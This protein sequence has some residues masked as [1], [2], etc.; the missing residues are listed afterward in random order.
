M[1]CYTCSSST[2]LSLP[3]LGSLPKLHHLYHS[4][5]FF[6]AIKDTDSSASD[7]RYVKN[8]KLKISYL[9][10]FLLDNISKSVCILTSFEVSESLTGNEEKIDKISSSFTFLVHFL[11]RATYACIETKKNCPLCLF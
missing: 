9:W 8:E 6:R 3:V 7:Y 5:V 11:D 4:G 2:E 1:T 10:R